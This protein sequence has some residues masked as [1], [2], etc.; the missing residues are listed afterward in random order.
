MKVR[1]VRIGVITN[2]IKVLVCVNCLFVVYRQNQNTS[3]VPVSKFLV[4]FSYGQPA[5]VHC[6]VRNL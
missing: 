5:A 6:Y 4:R 2:W 3:S 1:C